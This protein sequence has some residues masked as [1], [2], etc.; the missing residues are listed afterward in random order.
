[1]PTYQYRC[2]KC[3]EQFEVWQSIHDDA[4]TTHDGECGGA[5]SKVMGAAGIVL[6]GSGF[7]RNDSR[8]NDS[9]AQP[10]KE[11]KDEGKTKETA[12]A[13]GSGDKGS[14]DKGSGDKKDKKKDT[15]AADSSTKPS[16]SDSSKS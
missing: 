13:N 7:Y 5:L 10:A 15:A 12:G 4:R 8:A 3:G 11:G 2:A 9:G 1:M 16:K 6:K 14:G